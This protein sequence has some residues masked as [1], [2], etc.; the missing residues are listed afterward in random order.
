MPSVLN[1][2]KTAA[3]K[4]SAFYRTYVELS[5]M[6]RHTAIDLGM[7]PEDAYEVAYK[8]VYGR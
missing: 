3:R 5:A 7:F 2:L 4:R 8:A 1:S 6:P